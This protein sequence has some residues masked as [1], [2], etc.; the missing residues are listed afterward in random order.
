MSHTTDTPQKMQGIRS[1]QTSDMTH[2]VSCE[3]IGILGDVEKWYA[4][5]AV[6]DGKKM[7]RATPLGHRQDARS[8]EHYGQASEYLADYWNDINLRTYPDCVCVEVS[9]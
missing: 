5:D 1:L 8:F 9:Q 6:N 3:K 7:F 4:R 2:R